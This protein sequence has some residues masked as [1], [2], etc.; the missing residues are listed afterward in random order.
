MEKDLGNK[1]TFSGIIL[2][3]CISI[4]SICC[5]LMIVHESAKMAERNNEFRIR[6]EKEYGVIVPA[7]SGNICIPKWIIFEEEK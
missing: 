1:V 5:F 3:L 6:C 4:I 2:L 7:K